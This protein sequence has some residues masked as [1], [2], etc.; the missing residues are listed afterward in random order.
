MS[1]YD[2]EKKDLYWQ[3]TGLECKLKQYKDIEEE[4]GI[5]LI[6]SFKA[7]KNGIWIKSGDQ[8]VFHKAPYKT[9]AENIAYFRRLF[10]REYADNYGI[11]WALTR[12]E[13]E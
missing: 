3:I 7:C 9:L 8:I 13:L 4:F 6:T 1:E 10:E 12:E 5:D 11:T 2:S